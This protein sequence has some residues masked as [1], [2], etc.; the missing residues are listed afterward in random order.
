MLEFFGG[1]DVQRTQRLKGPAATFSREF[2][3]RAAKPFVLMRTIFEGKLSKSR[4]GEI[5]AQMELVNPP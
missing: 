5:N 3:P 4:G 2:R 1:S